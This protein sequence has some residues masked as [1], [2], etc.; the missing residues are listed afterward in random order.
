M[1]TNAALSLGFGWVLA[2]YLGER[3]E[4]RRSVG[5]WVLLVLGIYVAEC[6][7]FSASMATNILGYCLAFVWGILFARRLQ[8]R[9]VLLLSLY[10]CLPAVS[11]LSLLALLAVGGWPLLS[12]EGG[13]RF[14]IPAFVPWPFCTLLG[15]FLAVSA[16]AAV[17][18]T[19][20]TTLT[21]ATL[22]R[23]DTA[24]KYQGG[25]HTQ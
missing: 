17:F 16:S 7:A 13:R 10:T 11:F 6:V 15:F 24:T 20:I 14:G 23:K 25:R 19:A 22:R 3:P 4:S 9:E 12:V 21:A 18:K 2:K 1:V 8:A 5:S